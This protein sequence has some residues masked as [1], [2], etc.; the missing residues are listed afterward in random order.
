MLTYLNFLV[1]NLDVHLRL[2]VFFPAILRPHCFPS[3]KA[4]VHSLFF[5]QPH[6]IKKWAQMSRFFLPSH[7]VDSDILLNPPS[8]PH[9]HHSVCV[10]YTSTT[11]CTDRTQIS[12]SVEYSLYLL[13]V[14][15]EYTSVYLLLNRCMLFFYLVFTS[16]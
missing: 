12:V 1:V 13:L 6:S 16:A 11:L 9:M 15:A 8:P 5:L 7:G 2:V 3:D 4:T 14:S 10:C